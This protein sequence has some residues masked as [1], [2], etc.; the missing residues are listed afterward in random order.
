[1]SG[2]D[3]HLF[4]LINTDLSNAVF[5]FLMPLVANPDPFVIPVAVAG[6]GLMV[7]GGRKGRFLVVT[8]LLLLLVTNGLSEL[9]KL[10]IQRPRPCQVLESVRVLAGC[11]GR[12]FAFPSSHAA[13]VTAQALLFA[14]AYRPLALPLF[15]VAAI[16][17]YSRV[18]TGVHYPTDVV[19]GVVIG[20]VCGLVFIRLAREAER[21]L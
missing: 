21:R 10:W 6:V 8:A 9:L 5:D 1:M 20:L 11:S 4:R 19:G 3:L 2:L 14:S 16:V 13:N 17:G 7:W 18:Y 15:L 12:S